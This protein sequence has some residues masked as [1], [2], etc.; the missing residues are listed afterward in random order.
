MPPG[1]AIA[2]DDGFEAG[3]ASIQTQKSR[4][5]RGLSRGLSPAGKGGRIYLSRLFAYALLRK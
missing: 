5:G 2:A 4:S 1:L 3:P